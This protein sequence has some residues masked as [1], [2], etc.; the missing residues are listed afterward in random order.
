MGTRGKLIIKGKKIPR[1]KVVEYFCKKYKHTGRSIKNLLISSISTKYLFKLIKSQT[2]FY[3]NDLTDLW[4]KNREQDKYEIYNFGNVKIIYRL[5]PKYFLNIYD[6]KEISISEF[7]FITTLISSTVP[8]TELPSTKINSTSHPISGRRVI[9][10][11]IF[12]FSSFVGIIIEQ[13]GLSDV[14]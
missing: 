6:I 3:Y 10:S 4:F 9:A 11:R 7:S 5:K 13:L 12:P 1:K 8:S 2:L 14:G